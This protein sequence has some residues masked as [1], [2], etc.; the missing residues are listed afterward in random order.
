MAG[1][2]EVPM[3]RKLYHQAMEAMLM[4]SSQGDTSP[5]ISRVLPGA[6]VNAVVATFE[7][8]A[9]LPICGVSFGALSTLGEHGHIAGRVGRFRK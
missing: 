9:F 7:N 5:D 8:G 2:L 3:T 4:A 6:V 1:R